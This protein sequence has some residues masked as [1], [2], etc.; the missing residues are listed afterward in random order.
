M[1]LNDIELPAFLVADIYRSSLIDSNNIP[2]KETIVKQNIQSATSTESDSQW[3]W[4]GNN[5]KNILVIINNNEALHLPDNELS[6][7]TGILGA[8]KLNLA[9]VAIDAD[10]AAAIITFAVANTDEPKVPPRYICAPFNFVA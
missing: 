8:C 4:L 3:K 7:L 6:F 5:Q 10:R 1:S 9:D 2:A